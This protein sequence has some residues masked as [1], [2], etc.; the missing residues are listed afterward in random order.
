MNSTQNSDSLG[1]VVTVSR[2]SSPPMLK[3]KI[4]QNKTIILH[5]TCD[6]LSYTFVS[7]T[8]PRYPFVFSS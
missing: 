2:A 7:H 1:N 3:E 8:P 5:F 6:A 4:K